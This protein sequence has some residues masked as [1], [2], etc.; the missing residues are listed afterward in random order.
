MV[1]FCYFVNWACML[2]IF[3]PNML[4]GKLLL[5]CFVAA[6]GVRGEEKNVGCR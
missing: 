1:D 5:V 3:F 2:S 4:N 6:N